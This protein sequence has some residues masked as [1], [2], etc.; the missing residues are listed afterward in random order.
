MRISYVVCLL[1]T[2]YVFLWGQNVDFL[3]EI[4]SPEIDFTGEWRYEKKHPHRPQLDESFV[5]TIFKVND[6][7]RGIYCMKANNGEKMDCSD[8]E[9]LTLNEEG[10]KLHALLLSQWG[11][12]VKG[13]LSVKSQKELSWKMEQHIGDAFVPI[14]MTLTG[15][16]SL[17]EIFSTQVTL[18][19]ETNST[20]DLKQIPYDQTALRLDIPTRMNNSQ[21]VIGV[22]SNI[23]RISV[24]L[25]SDCSPKEECILYLVTTNPEGSQVGLLKLSPHIVGTLSA[26]SERT[27]AT[28][29]RIDKD[30]KI[31][32]FT[33]VFKK[34]KKKS[35][36]RI[37]YYINNR[38]EILNL[39]EK[40]ESKKKK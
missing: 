19:L 23:P 12:M 34:G 18:P 32:L 4:G 31:T 28:S 10:N 17:Y 9:N 2:S 33:S 14:E 29:Y 22:E 40:Q 7:Y 5:L 15:N 27:E 26:K 36:G 11:G 8:K 6:Q 24:Y 1:C 39:E 37:Q 21:Y 25:V 13:T 3:S 16:N 35:E 20:V 30:L 38:G